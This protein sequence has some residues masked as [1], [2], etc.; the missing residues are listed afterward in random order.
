MGGVRRASVIVVPDAL[1]HSTDPRWVCSLWPVLLFTSVNKTR[2]SALGGLR[3]HCY[4]IMTVSINIT[5]I[6]MAIAIMI[7]FK[8]IIATIVTTAIISTPS[9]PPSP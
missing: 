5:V 4:H 8:T 2:M 1:M 7:I 6:I 3:Q 9:S